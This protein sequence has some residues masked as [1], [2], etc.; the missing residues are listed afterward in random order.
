MAGRARRSGWAA[1][2]LA[3]TATL[4]DFTTILPALAGGYT[5]KRSVNFDLI[6]HYDTL[7]DEVI[8]SALRWISV[9]TVQEFDAE[10]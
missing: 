5:L 8:E 6:P 10:P 7:P 9:W 2:V 4:F 3:V 1:I